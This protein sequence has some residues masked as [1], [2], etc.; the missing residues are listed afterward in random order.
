[1]SKVISVFSVI[2][3]RQL[4][5]VF[6]FPGSFVVSDFGPD[7]AFQLLTLTAGLVS[8]LAFVPAKFQRLLLPRALFIAWPWDLSGTW[9]VR[10]CTEFSLGPCTFPGK[11]A[12]LCILVVIEMMRIYRD[13]VFGRNAY[14]RGRS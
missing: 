3:V 5:Q 11:R 4:T 8:P 12:F 10:S 1:M 9:P 6:V 14:R 2:G 13:P 7:H